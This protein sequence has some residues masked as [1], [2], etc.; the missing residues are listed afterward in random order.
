MRVLRHADKR[1]IGTMKIY[2]FVVVALNV[3]SSLIMM[4]LYLH[5][6]KVKNGK[7]CKHVG[8]LSV[9]FGATLGIMVWSFVIGILVSVFAGDFVRLI[10]I[11]TV[12]STISLVPNVLGA[13]RVSAINR[14]CPK[15]CAG[16]DLFCKGKKL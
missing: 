14:Y 9:H 10:Q 4:R 8:F 7:V 12:G 6:H 1:V 2:L 3:I 15:E 16:A 5:Y 13:I 11:A